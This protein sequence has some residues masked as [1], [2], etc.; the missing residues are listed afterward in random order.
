MAPRVAFHTLGCKV[1]QY[2]TRA[3]AALFRDAGYEVVDF[4][5]PAEVYVINTCTVTS[6]G[7]KKSRQALRRAR[8]Q[9]PAAVVVAMGCYAQTAPDEVASLPGVDVVV[10]TTGRRRLVELVETARRRKGAAPVPPPPA[11]GAA[12]A[13][14]PLTRES[15][16]EELGE[17]AVPERARATVKVQ[18]GCRQYCSYCKVPY[19]RG[20]ERSRPPAAVRAEVERLVAE[21]FREV[22]LTG[23]HLGSY[24]RD[25]PAEPR[26]DLAR[27]AG[28][29]ARV[30]GLARLRLSSLEPTDVTDA[31]ITLV[32]ENPV[33]CR[34][35]HLPL[36]SGDDAI[37]RRMNRHYTTAEYARVVERIRA[38]VPGAALTTD[39]IAGFPG[40]TEEHFQRTLAFVR[41]MAFSRLHVFPYSRRRGTPAASFPSQVPEAVKRERAGRLIALGR[42]LSLAFHQPL[43][44]R[45]V[46]VLF[47]E[48]AGSWWSGLTDT[49][50][51]VLALSPVPLGGEIKP[52][53]VERA[54]AEEVYGRVEEGE[55]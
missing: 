22:V 1:N 16:F 4:S 52:V 28:E 10:G 46:T 41:E 45:T 39:L 50:V 43:V 8:R 25:L 51:R 20:P 13:V 18:E 23:I 5:S 32:G 30:P 48:A 47:E 17:G 37:L 9:N 35:F 34:H 7:D 53:R 19:A 55:G 29:I 11:A 2:D 33:L 42:E 3:V 31:L 14:A 15:E 38:A 12:V 21:G 44:G 49:Y 26:W 36:Q 54:E 24:G 6:L 27:L 40:E